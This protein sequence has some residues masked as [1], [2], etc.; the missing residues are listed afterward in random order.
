TAIMEEILLNDSDY[1]TFDHEWSLMSFLLYRQRCIDFELDKHKEHDRYVRRLTAV[2]NWEQSSNDAIKLAKYAINELHKEKK[3]KSIDMFWESVMLAENR[4]MIAI[5]KRAVL[6]EKQTTTVTQSA[7]K[8]DLINHDKEN[9]DDNYSRKREHTSEDEEDEGEE[10]LIK[11]NLRPRKKANYVD[12]S[13]SDLSENYPQEN[14]TLKVDEYKSNEQENDDHE[15]TESLEE[16]HLSNVALPLK[17]HLQQTS[18]SSVLK[19]Y[20]AKKTTSP[21]DPAHSFIIDLSSSSKI[22]DEFS[23]EWW[24]EFL[25]RR[26]EAVKKTYHYEIE[27]FIIHLFENNMDLS[28]ARLKWYELRNVAAPTYNNEFSYAENDWEKIRR[29]IERVIGQFLDAFESSRNP[30]QNNCLEREWTGDYIIP[31]IQGVLKLDGICYIPWGE[32][33]VLATQYRRNNEKDIYME[34]VA[35]SHLADLL[36]KYEQYEIVCGLIC[37]GPLSYD[38]TKHSFDQFHLSRMMKDMLDDLELKFLNSGKDGL[39]LYTIGIQTHMTEVNV[40]LIEKREVYFL[41]HLKSFNLPLS[42]SAYQSL[43]GALRVA[44]NIRGLVNSLIQKF[45]VI[46]DNNDGFKTPPSVSDNKKTQETPP[47]QPKK[48]GEKGKNR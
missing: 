2:L 19:K 15:D 18:L 48:K 21:Y 7:F 37:G 24:S 10:H 42:F 28:Q 22:K 35:R 9:T 32:I 11:W 5:S 44:W 38:I 29:W 33:S 13:S 40:Y 27:P 25:K 1:F 43:K 17:I 12:V 36:C 31:L 6:T 14:V 8:Q 20:C 46:F 45:D 23:N 16:L 4:K 39:K 47:K 30:L 26:P 3:S 41:H 34:K